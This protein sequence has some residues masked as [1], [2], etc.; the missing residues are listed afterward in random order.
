RAILA[1][2]R[3]TILFVPSSLGAN[4]LLASVR[5]THVSISTHANV[6]RLRVAAGARRVNVA[7]VREPS[8]LQVAAIVFAPHPSALRL[9][10][11]AAQQY[12]EGMAQQLDRIAA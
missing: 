2:L 8:G 12:I 7:I 3:P 11:E 5:G 4:R 1:A 6:E 9:S 10:R